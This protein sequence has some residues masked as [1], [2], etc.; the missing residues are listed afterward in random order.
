M[1]VGGA[2]CG[3]YARRQRSSSTTGLDGAASRTPSSGCEGGSCDV[4]TKMSSCSGCEMSS[5][6][7]WSW[8]CTV[9]S[10]SESMLNCGTEEAGGSR[11]AGGGAARGG[12]RGAPIGSASREASPAGAAGG[13]RRGSAPPSSGQSCGRSAATLPG[14]RAADPSRQTTGDGHSG[15]GRKSSDGGLLA[16]ASRGSLPRESRG[17]AGGWRHPRPQKPLG[18]PTEPTRETC[19]PRASRGGGA[20]RASCRAGRGRGG[21]PARSA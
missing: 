12:G 2:D 14:R 9:G 6:K 19:T 21:R 11:G 8:A 10:D 7:A 17:D 1:F 4:S 20:W 13:A 3:S 5:R 18:I 15:G 16:P